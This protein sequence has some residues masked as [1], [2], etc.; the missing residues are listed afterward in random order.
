M[1]FNKEQLEAINHLKGAAMVIA[2][3]G[4]GKSTVLVERVKQLI[5]NGAKGSDILVI[6]FTDNSSKDLKKKF[7][8]NNIEG[9]VLGTFHSVCRRILINEGIDASKQLVDYQ[10]ENEFKKID[11]NVK[12]KAVKSFIGYQKNYGVGVNDNFE[13]MESEYDEDTLREFYNTYENFKTKKH[14]LDFED[15]LLLTIDILK[16]NPNKYTYKY[17]MI[18]E[19]QDNNKIQYELIKLL[20]PSNNTMVIGDFRQSIFSFRGSNPE[21]FMNFN[22]VYTDAKIINLNVNYR[23]TN[24]IVDTSNEFI[25]KYY[26]DYEF[27]EDSIA[28]NKLNGDIL[29]YDNVDKIQE[30][31]II[32]NKIEAKLKKGTSPNE[33]AVLYRLNQNSFNIENELKK[34]DIPYHIS[35]TDGNFFNRKE[36]NGI[37]CMLRLIDNPHDDMAYDAIYNTRMHP[38]TFMS[39]VLRDRI[40]DLSITKDISLFEASEFVKVDKTFQRKVLNDFNKIILDLIV[41]HKKKGKSLI[42]LVDNIIILLKIP[43]FINTHYEGDALEERLESLTA[44]K[45]FIRDNT[46]ESFLKFVYGSNKSS[47]KCTKDDIELMTIHKSKG[48]EFENVF[49]VGV[50]DDKFPNKKAPIEEEARLFY[51]AST[52]P[53]QNLYISQIGIGN[54]FV[55][56]YMS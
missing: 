56:E 35:S 32:V 41:Q 37:M 53:K 2:G 29:Q 26:G 39:N 46:L 48:L 51:V 21:L 12:Y 14:A 38:F 18:D 24:N 45:T 49:I 43:E 44:L 36:I 40:R 42:N 31:E 7:A 34:R 50:E 19:S 8:E 28:K 47:K 6:T 3:A 16:K 11:K 4:S 17:I 52:R 27:Y 55:D 9:M 22:K 54:R 25:K 33:I 23:S 15:W 13:Y 20:C 10:V 5:K 1:K 30:S